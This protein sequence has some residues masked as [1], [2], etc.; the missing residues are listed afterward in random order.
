MAKEESWAKGYGKKT[1]YQQSYADVVRS[2]HSN[3]EGLKPNSQTRRLGSQRPDHAFSGLKVKSSSFDQSWVVEELSR[4]GIAHHIQ[5]DTMASLDSSSCDLS[6]ERK[7]ESGGGNTKSMVQAMFDGEQVQIND[8]ARSIAKSDRL[9]VPM[10]SDSADLGK[11]LEERVEREVGSDEGFGG[12]QFMSRVSWAGLGYENPLQQN[13]ETREV[14]NT[15]SG[16]TRQIQYENSPVK[17]RNGGKKKK[18]KTASPKKKSK[19][20]ELQD[21]SEAQIK[22]SGETHRPSAAIHKGKITI[23]GN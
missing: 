14:S 12:P 21:T 6:S 4:G 23:S 17:L 13:T 16:N 22:G 2:K 1:T 8:D 7:K 15:V 9:S 18:T 5:R 10:E 19:A 20:K 3:G 11:G